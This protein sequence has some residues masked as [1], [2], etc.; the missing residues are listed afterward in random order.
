MFFFRQRL[1]RHF[2]SLNLF[3]STVLIFILVTN[4]LLVRGRIM[5][6]LR[7]SAILLFLLAGVNG[8]RFKMNTGDRQCLREEI[9]KNVVLTG[10]YELVRLW[11]TRLVFM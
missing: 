9:H 2:P 7:V 1:I 4:I 6:L 8:L 11:D 3:D 5:S 10:E